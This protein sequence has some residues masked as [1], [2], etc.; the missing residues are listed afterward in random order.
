MKLSRNGATGHVRIV[1]QAS[2]TSLR[3]TLIGKFGRTDAVPSFAR[4]MSNPT[5]FTPFSCRE[6][7]PA[8]PI[9][10]HRPPSSCAPLPPCPSIACPR[11]WMWTTRL[12]RASTTTLTSHVHAS[13]SRMRNTYSM[14]GVLDGWMLRPTRSI[15]AKG[16]WKTMTSLSWTQSGSSGWE[17]FS[18]VHPEV[19][20]SS[21]SIRRLQN[22]DPPD[23][24]P[25]G[26]ETGNQWPSSI[27]RVGESC[28][29]RTA[30]EP[31][32][33]S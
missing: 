21:G 3:S 20:V 13:Y 7:V 30:Q 8:K 25:S 11:S 6:L 24:D 33:S 14:V 16:W 19:F 29:T 22:R 5:N 2:W 4:N 23:Q 10:R 26:N 28:S 27:W 9:F 1:E 18:V 15:W 31:T 12:Y 32:S 17:W